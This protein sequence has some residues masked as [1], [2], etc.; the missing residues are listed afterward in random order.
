MQIYL[1]IQIFIIIFKRKNSHFPPRLIWT[2]CVAFLIGKYTVTKML[3]YSQSLLLGLEKEE[4]PRVRSRNCVF[5]IFMAQ[6]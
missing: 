3:M 2:W 5:Q 6:N 4:Y 1:P